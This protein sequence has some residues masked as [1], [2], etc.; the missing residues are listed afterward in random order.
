M[1]F[2]NLDFYRFITVFSM[3]FKCK[4][5]KVKDSRPRIWFKPN[6]LRRPPLHFTA[7]AR[8]PSMIPTENT[9]NIGKI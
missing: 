7:I 9:A 4:T 3:N 2:D 8:Q 5:C 6:M 1:I